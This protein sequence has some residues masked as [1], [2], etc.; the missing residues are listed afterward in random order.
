MSHALANESR[1]TAPAY[2]PLVTIVFAVASGILI[3]HFF[4]GSF[5]KVALFG[6]AS[7]GWI[8]LVLGCFLGHRGKWRTSC[9]LLL[10]SA[11]ALAALWHH[12]NWF[13][14]GDDDLTL[15]LHPGVGRQPVCIE[16]VALETPRS[17]WRQSDADPL[18]GFARSDHMSLLVEIHI[19]R[20]GDR[21]RSAS[22]CAQ[23]ELDASESDLEAG[24]TFRAFARLYPLQ[25]ALN[26]GQFDPTFN[27]RAQRVGCALRV[28]RP[29]ALTKLSIGT[30]LSPRRWMERIRAAGNQLFARYLSTQDA[31]LASRNSARHSRSTRPS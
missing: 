26:P 16:G 8:A 12:E 21:W 27:E 20:D 13:L 28:A 9:V 31:A 25:G 1:S 5:P 19:I 3:D 4:G 24:D 23:M 11:S 7:L 15:F 2:C 10:L 18:R 6:A 29:E 14:F 17:F 30:R 22:G